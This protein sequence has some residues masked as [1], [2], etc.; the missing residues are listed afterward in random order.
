MGLCA[1]VHARDL[2]PEDEAALSGPALRVTARPVR[3]GEVLA[4]CNLV[5]CHSPATAAAALMNERPVVLTPEHVEQGMVEFR[6]SRQGL[7]AG[8]SPT[9]DSAT[10]QSVLRRALDDPDLA[11]RAVGFARHYHGFD[12]AESIGAIAEECEIVL[13]ASRTVAT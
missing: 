10:V 5:L 2:R 4:S 11:T 8:L 6:L 1:L 7:A 9:A 12:P 13:H 3:M